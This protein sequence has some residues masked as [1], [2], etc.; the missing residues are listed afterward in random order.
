MR[1]FSTATCCGGMIL[2]AGMSLAQP[3]PGG[4]QQQPGGPMGGMDHRTMDMPGHMHSMMGAMDT[5]M[6]G[7]P[8]RTA[9]GVD[10]D[11]LLMMIP[12]HQ[13]AIDMARIVIEQGQDEETKAVAREIIEDQEEE[14]AK[15]RA[16]LQR[17]GVEAPAAPTR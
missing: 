4:P 17:L 14:L 10:A 2:A 9:G 7:M 3:Q 16:I 8:T 15:M 12:H 13:S 1:L 5:M 11:F 6:Q